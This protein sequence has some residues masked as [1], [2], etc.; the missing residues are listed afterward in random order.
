MNVSSLQNTCLT[1]DARAAF[2]TVVGII[3][4]SLRFSYR[5][6]LESFL[7]LFTPEF[8]SEKHEV[9]SV[10]TKALL[11]LMSKAGV[12]SPQHLVCY[13]RLKYS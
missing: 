10:R 6:Q 12:L 7:P 11:L 5:N 13:F 9:E 3:P 8:Y 1:E 4:D 2:T